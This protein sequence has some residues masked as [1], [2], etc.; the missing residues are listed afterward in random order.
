MVRPALLLVLPVSILSLDALAE[1][2]P[3]ANL[4]IP[5]EPP[6]MGV[7]FGC[8]MS[9]PV[10]QVHNVGSHVGNDAWAWDFRMPEGTPVVAARDGIVRL[11]RGD[12]DEGGCDPSL[13][14]KANYV[15]LE[16]DGGLETQYLH[17]SVVSVLPGQRVRRGDL[18]G[19]SGKTGWACG[20]HLHFK[21]ATPT[22]AGW[23]NPSVEARLAGF[24]DPALESWVSSPP[25]STSVE[26]A[27][28]LP[29]PVPAPAAP[30]EV[31][32][33]A[34]AATVHPPAEPRAPGLSERRAAAAGV[35]P[36]R[37]VERLERAPVEHP[38]SAGGSP[39]TSVMPA[40]R[41]AAPLG[42]GAPASALVPAGPVARPPLGAP[43]VVPRAH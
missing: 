6:E 21:V 7:P 3:T 35:V 29:R 2:A 28:P 13:A 23:N 32:S 36:A 12:S 34:L 43:E 37:A 20:A 24:G 17:F 22:T 42:P 27:R 39:L 40:V 41:A 26:I 1:S 5:L 9:F 30:G 15:V 8:G 10:S 18:L 38:L 31:Q 19:Y 25:C 11:A 4:P 33:A 14:R 16:H